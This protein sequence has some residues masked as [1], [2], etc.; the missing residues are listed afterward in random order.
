MSFHHKLPVLETEMPIVM[1]APDGL[2]SREAAKASKYEP[3]LLPI[4]IDAIAQ[5]DP[6]RVLAEFLEA[7]HHSEETF[8]LTFGLF[9]RVTDRLSWWMSAIGK[10]AELKTFDT[11]ALAGFLD[12]RHYAMLVA[13]IKCGY[14]VPTH[15][16]LF[17]LAYTDTNKRG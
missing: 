12:F 10:Q 8:E 1:E 16:H 14:K 6:S 5:S 7:P 4:T 17:F 13:A 9:A 2:T 15:F 11:I 3:R